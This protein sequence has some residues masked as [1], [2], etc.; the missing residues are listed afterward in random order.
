M[1]RQGLAR[2]QASPPAPWWLCFFAT[3]AISPGGRTCQR[4]SISTDGGVGAAQPMRNSA[5]MIAAYFIFLLVV[6]IIVDLDRRA[7]AL[8]PGPNPLRSVAPLPCLPCLA[9]GL[10]AFEVHHA[11][12]AKP[13]MLGASARDW[14]APLAAYRGVCPRIPGDELAGAVVAKGLGKPQTAEPRHPAALI[15]VALGALENRPA[16]RR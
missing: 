3:T 5:A 11:V 9:S 13:V 8:I 4:I 6:V 14:L 10:R 1:I 7:Q 16:V 15:S 2:Y 12:V